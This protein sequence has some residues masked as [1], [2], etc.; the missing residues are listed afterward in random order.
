MAAFDVSRF[1]SFLAT[2]DTGSKVRDELEREARSV[3]DGATILV[4]FDAVEA[5]TISFADEFIGRLLAAR[6]SGDLPEV[7]IVIT[8]LND[9][10]REALSVCLERRDVSAV[11]REGRQLR[12]LAGDEY[13]GATFDAARKRKEFRA[14]DIASDLGITPQ[15]A[16]NRLKKLVDY[17]ALTRARTAPRGGGKEFI[18]RVPGSG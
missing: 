18:Y 5:V 9:E 6:A 3:G 12:L 1:G 7:A 2:R 16:N 4:S 17:G 10:V 8:D 15:S 14:G 13:L 11:A